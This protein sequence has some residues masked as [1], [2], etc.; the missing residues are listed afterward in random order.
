MS[1]ELSLAALR[2]HVAT[3]WLRVRDIFAAWDEDGSGMIERSEW[4]KAVKTLFSVNA[5]HAEALFDSLDVDASGSLS[6]RELQ[7]KL[8]PGADVE[9][10]AVLRA[11]ALGEIET[12][13]SNRHSLRDGPQ[14]THSR[15]VRIEIAPAVGEGE[16]DDDG[17]ASLIERLRDALAASWTRVKDL[18]VEWDDDGRCAASTQT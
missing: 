15:V 10:D 6:F 2:D 8:R 13:A 1:F 16:M 14:T 4:S 11:G 5:Q 9:L 7:H 17:G 3:E 18:W 12:T